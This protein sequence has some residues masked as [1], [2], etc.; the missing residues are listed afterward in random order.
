MNT[1]SHWASVTASKRCIIR[2]RLL[3]ATCQHHQPHGCRHRDAARRRYACP[4]HYH[5]LPSPLLSAPLSSSGPCHVRCRPVVRL[6]TGDVISRSGNQRIAGRACSRV[7]S[8]TYDQRALTVRRRQ[9]TRGLRVDNVREKTSQQLRELPIQT[10]AQT[11][12]K[13]HYRNAKA[14]YQVSH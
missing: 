3:L 10:V 2:R 11:L 14:V 9:D 1:I 12:K 7:H 8:R 4:I 6:T 5:P 13:S